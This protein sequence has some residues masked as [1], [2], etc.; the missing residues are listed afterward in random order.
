MQVPGHVSKL[1]NGRQGAVQGCLDL[2]VVLAQRRFD[3]GHPHA[4]VDRFLGGAGDAG[5]GAAIVVA[6]KQ[7]VLAQQQPLSNRMFP[8]PHVVCLGPGEVLQGSPPGLRIDNAQISL[9]AAH[10]DDR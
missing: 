5:P 9:N 7:A 10:C 6:T 3:V 2:A 1:H 4:V 8:D